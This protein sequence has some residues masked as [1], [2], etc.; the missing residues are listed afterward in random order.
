MATILRDLYAAPPASKGKTLSEIVEVESGQFYGKGY[1]DIQ[2]RTPSIA[3]AKECLGWSPTVGLEVALK[4]TL[5][6]FIAE[7]T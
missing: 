1:Q 7:S 2:T 6:A 3:R 4:K 5:D